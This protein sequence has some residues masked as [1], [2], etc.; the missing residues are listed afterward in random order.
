MKTKQ[1]QLSYL[2]KELKEKKERRVK[3]LEWKLTKEQ[4]EYIENV[5]HLRVEPYLYGI[6]TKTFKNISKLN[7]SILKDIHYSKKRGKNFEVRKLSAKEKEI[8][9]E[10]GIC[11]NPIK[12]KIY[13]FS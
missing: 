11:Y 10:Y 8:L 9:D 6:R 5:L 2:K 13:L 1:Y 7:C 3:V 4:K 12:Y